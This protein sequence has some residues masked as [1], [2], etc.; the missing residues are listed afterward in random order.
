MMTLPV[1]CLVSAFGTEIISCLFS[2]VYSTSSPALSILMFGFTFMTL[3][4]VLTTILTAGGRPK[5]AMTMGLILLPVDALLNL[6]LI[7]RYDLVGAALATSSTSVI[8]VMMASAVIFRRFGVLLE[9]RSLSRIAISSLA[10]YLLAIGLPLPSLWNAVW[11]VVLIPGYAVLLILSGELGR[12]DWNI[13]KRL[14][15]GVQSATTTGQ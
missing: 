13:V 9:V 10:I 3:F 1:A 14:I 4:S 15:P 8:G 7:P 12:E 2:R 11:G 6:V 5:A